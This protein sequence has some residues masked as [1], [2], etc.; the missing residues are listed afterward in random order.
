MRSGRYTNFSAIVAVL[1]CH[2]DGSNQAGVSSTLPDDP[3]RFSAGLDDG[4]STSPCDGADDF[5]TSLDDGSQDGPDDLPKEF[6]NG[7]RNRGNNQST[8][9]TQHRYNWLFHLVSP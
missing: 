7:F 6:S 1:C 2:D 4:L 3:D 5:T 8:D 9:S